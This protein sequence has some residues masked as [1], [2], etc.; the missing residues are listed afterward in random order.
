MARHKDE[1]NSID[2]AFGKPLPQGVQ[3]RGPLQYRARKLVE[4]VRQT[5]T[6]D[7]ARMAKQWLEDTSVAVR[8]G[9]YVNTRP[10]DKITLAQLVQRFVD[11]EMQEG[12]DRRGA[13][14]DMGHIP[15]LIN[16]AIGQLALSK[17]MPSSVRDFRVRQLAAGYAKSTVVKRMNLLA[18]I[19]KHARS[20]WDDVPLREN[21]AS[22]KEV[23]RPKNADKKRKRRLRVPSPAAARLALSRGEE[24]P[25]TEEQALLAAIGKSAN[26]WDL[27]LTK[28]AIAQATRQGEALGLRWCDVNMEARTITLYGT[29]GKGVKNEEAREEIGPEVRPVMPAAL[30]ILKAVMPGDPDPADLVFPAGP[31]DAFKVRYGRIVARAAGKMQ[32]IY[33]DLH[34]LDELTYHDLRH[35]ATTR[36]AKVF[37]REDLKKVTGHKDYKSLDRYYQ[38]DPTELAMI[39]EEYELAQKSGVAVEDLK[40]PVAHAAE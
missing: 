19:L 1:E 32:G 21:V 38:P 37:K 33:K 26:P 5:K 16:D 18:T 7:S 6:F 9:S 2:P 20:E 22:A 35:E 10:L 13:L 28:W 17:L 27:W 31:Q 23:N 36:L 40:E 14:H 30:D 34:Y 24:A 12:G 8:A 11:E 25:V 4:G 29:H 3:Y 39:A 15:A